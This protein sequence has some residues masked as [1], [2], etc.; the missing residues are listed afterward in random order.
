[1]FVFVFKQFK[2]SNKVAVLHIIVKISSRDKQ[3]QKLVSLHT[4]SFNDSFSF[5]SLRTAA[6]LFSSMLGLQNQYEAK[7]NRTLIPENKTIT[8]PLYSVTFT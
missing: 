2:E 1:M 6:S 5:E 4:C 8:K 7:Y 3:C